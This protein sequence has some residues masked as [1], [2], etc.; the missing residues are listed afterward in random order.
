MVGREIGMKQAADYNADSKHEM[1]AQAESGKVLSEWG[2][3][4]GAE[5]AQAMANGFLA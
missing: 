4:A 3:P 1:L 2:K 5:F